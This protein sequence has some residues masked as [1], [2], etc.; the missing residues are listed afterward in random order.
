[1]SGTSGDPAMFCANCGN[2]LS[3]HA[4]T[5]G[6]C[7]TPVGS[8]ATLKRPTLVTVLAIL[9]LLSAA[10][11]LLVG[12]LAVAS[13]DARSDVLGSIAG[14]VFLGL[15]VVQLACGV[16]LWLLKPWGRTL[17]ISLAGLG[18]LGV[19][20]GTI[21]SVL[22][23]VYFFKPGVKVLFSGKPP[24]E[25]TAEEQAQVGAI[26]QGSLA[27]ITVVVLVMVASVAALG[28][29]AAIAIPS[30]IRARAA[31]NEASAIGSLRAIN[32]AQFA[33]AAACG[34]GYYA[35][36]LASLATPPPGEAQGFVA[37]DL[38]SDPSYK[39]QYR[40]DLVAGDA[41]P[42]A[43]EACNGAAVVATYFV[44]A[45]PIEPGS[46][47]TR[48]FATNERGTIFQSTSPIAVTH[49]AAP[50]NTTPVNQP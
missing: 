49:G 6:Y 4:T 20:L 15:G 37:G 7:G 19:P 42:D 10:F 43:P 36:T 34:H 31:G 41:V 48:R 13:L 25:F 3:L 46:S 35:P 22:I 1:M 5:C 45:E 33:F 26:A 17:Q 16:G 21:V 23:L 29:V 27:T 11:G 50:P 24:S 9:N 38:A 47:G 39:S 12:I 2:T 18:L 30:L 44:S 28:V 14:L 32:S 40:I 8:R